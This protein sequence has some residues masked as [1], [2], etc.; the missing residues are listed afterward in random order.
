VSL[1]LARVFD[2]LQRLPDDVQATSEE[3]GPA[4]M[5]LDLTAGCLEQAP[6]LQEHD[7]INFK[8]MLFCLF[9]L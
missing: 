1:N 6:S 5:A 9:S 4:S 2:L 7:P 8:L 3:T